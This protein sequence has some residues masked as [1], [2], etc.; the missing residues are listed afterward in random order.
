[1]HII[2]LTPSCDVDGHCSGVVVDVGT[3]D[4]VATDGSYRGVDCPGCRSKRI[5]RGYRNRLTLCC[6]R[7]IAIQVA[8]GF[9]IV[10]DLDGAV[11]LIDRCYWRYDCFGQETNP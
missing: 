7:G 5:Y 4:A 1:M 10:L 11:V 3:P 9:G 6:K 2:R 8:I